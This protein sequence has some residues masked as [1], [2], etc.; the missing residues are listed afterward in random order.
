MKK[1]IKIKTE[2]LVP[3]PCLTVQYKFF[4]CNNLQ[5]GVTLNSLIKSNKTRT[6]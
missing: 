3:V 6:L 4:S 2:E 5:E 1:I